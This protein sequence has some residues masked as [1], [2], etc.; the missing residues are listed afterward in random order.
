M[1]YQ[2][3]GYMATKRLQY[4]KNLSRLTSCEPDIKIV[5]VVKIV[6]PHVIVLATFVAQACF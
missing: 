6:Y 2:I 3:V 4:S 1:K 5:H